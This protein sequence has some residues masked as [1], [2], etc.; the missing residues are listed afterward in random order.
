MNAVLLRLYQPRAP[1]RE[2]QREARRERAAAPEAARS[3][4][5][6]AAPRDVLFDAPYEPSI[7]GMVDEAL[8]TSSARPVR[9]VAALFRRPVKPERDA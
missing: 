8:P 1:H 4:R 5:K 9:G 3:P 7:A 6:P 2:P